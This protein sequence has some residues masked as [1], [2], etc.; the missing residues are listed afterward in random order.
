MAMSPSQS[1]SDPSPSQNGSRTVNERYRIN[2]RASAT[3]ERRNGISAAFHAVVMALAI[4]RT[5]GIKLNLDESGF[6]VMRKPPA[7]GTSPLNY[8]DGWPHTPKG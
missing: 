7:G 3:A 6:V 1:D 5:V 2:Y 8:P 4:S